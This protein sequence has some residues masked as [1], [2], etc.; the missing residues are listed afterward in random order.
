MNCA[1]FVEYVLREQFDKEFLFPQ[2]KGSIFLETEQIKDE[3]P[4]FVVSTSTPKDGDLV[5]MHGKRL[6]CHVGLYVR[7]GWVEYVL[8][9]EGTIKVSSLHRINDLRLYGYKMAGYYTWLK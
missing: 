5:L 1:E 7:I 3:M 6:M 2:S 9:T 4:K 8:H